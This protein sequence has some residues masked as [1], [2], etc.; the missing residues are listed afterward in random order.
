MTLRNNREIFVRFFE[1]VFEDNERLSL[2]FEYSCWFFDLIEV[3]S[4]KKMMNSR[5]RV[6][7]AE[8]LVRTIRKTNEFIR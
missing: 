8:Q 5:R 4:M 3:F 2:I 1:H 7:V 6:D